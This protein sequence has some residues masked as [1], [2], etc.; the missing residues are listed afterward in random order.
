MK[1]GIIG[2]LVLALLAKYLLISQLLEAG[3]FYSLLLFPTLGRWSMV[4]LA[5][6][7][8]ALP[9]EA[10]A[11]YPTS[12]DFWWAT[13]TALLCSILIHGLVGLGIMVLVWVC[14]YGLGHYC[15]RRIGGITIHVMG[16]GVELVEIF[17]LAVLVALLGGR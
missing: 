17:S 8:P 10:F 9:K 6:C 16:A 13:G 4:C 12:Q 2:V 3:S 5:W 14:S 1:K 15:V 11:A 7:F